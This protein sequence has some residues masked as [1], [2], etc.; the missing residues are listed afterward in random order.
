MKRMKWSERQFTLDAPEGW[1]YNVVERLRGTLPRL[2]ALTQGLQ[3]VQL[4]HKP[5]DKWSIKEHIGHLADL[6][7]LHEGRLDDFEAGKKELRPA[8]MSNK[9]TEAA[10]HND[11][12]LS[13]LLQGFQQKRNAFIQRLENLDDATQ[14]LRALHPRLK[15]TMRPIDIAEFT[16]EHDDHHLAEIRNIL[17][18]TKQA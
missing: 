16:A 4:V 6:E 1:L 17:K 9:K 14:K 5:N 18:T 11:Q 3:E 12:A 15:V 7:E 10:H 2:L 13:E 8:D